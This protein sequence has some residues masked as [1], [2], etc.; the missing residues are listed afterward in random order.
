VF[1]EFVDVHSETG[2]TEGSDFIQTLLCSVQ[3]HKVEISEL[4][5]IVTDSTPSVIGSKTVWGRLLLLLLLLSLLLLVFFF[6]SDAERFSK[7]Y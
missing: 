2:H 5:G 6:F 1:E 3:K 7:C 4:V